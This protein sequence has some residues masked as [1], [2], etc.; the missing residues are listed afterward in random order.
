MGR[1]WICCDLS[2]YGIHITKKRVLDIAELKGYKMKDYMSPFRPFMV[3]TLKDYQ[4]AKL[5]DENLHEN[6]DYSIFTFYQNFL[7]NSKF[8]LQVE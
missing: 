3:Q 4:I 8:Y 7:G 2:R 1:R 6:Q 5:G